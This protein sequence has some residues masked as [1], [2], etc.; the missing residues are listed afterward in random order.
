MDGGS[1]KGK[2]RTKRLGRVLVGWQRVNGRRIEEKFHRVA[3]LCLKGCFLPLPPWQPFMA[4]LLPFRRGTCR[5]RLLMGANK[6]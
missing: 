5:A 1:G 4:L 2:G 3:S 6:K